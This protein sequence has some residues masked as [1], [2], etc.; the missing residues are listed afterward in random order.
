MMNTEPRIPANELEQFLQ[1]LPAALQQAAELTGKPVRFHGLPIEE[2]AGPAYAIAALFDPYVLTAELPEIQVFLEFPEGELR[3]SRKEAIRFRS[4][5][6]RS[7]FYRLPMLWGG[8]PFRVLDPAGGWRE[9]AIVGEFP[10]CLVRPGEARFAFHPLRVIHRYLN[11][12]Q[13]ETT[14]DFTDLLIHAVLSAGECDMPLDDNEL[15]RDFHAFGI[16]CVLLCQLAICAGTEPDLQRVPALLRRAAAEY[17]SGNIPA[18]RDLLREG[19]EQLAE[20]R[21]RIVARP[22]YFMNIPHGGIQF[23][24]EGFAEYDSPEEAARMLNLYLDWLEKYNY[25]F[26]VDIGVN[27]LREFARANPRTFARLRE[28][29]ASDRVELVNGSFSQP[30][31]HLFPEWD[32]RM[33]FE[34]GQQVLE[35]LFGRRAVTFAAQEISLHPKLPDI[36]VD[37]GYRCA[38]HRCQNLGLAPIDTTPL[39]RWTGPEGKSLRALPSHPLRSDRRGA[40]IYR[41]L[42]VL[43][44]SERNG[45]LP[46]I[47][48][49]NFIDQSFVDI[50][51][52]EVVRANQYAEVW[53]KFVTPLEFFHETA[54]IPAPETRYKLDDYH[55][56]LGHGANSLH[57]H[58][59]GGLSSKHVLLEQEARQLRKQKGRGAELDRFL[60]REA[61]DCYIVPYF[62]TGSFMEG[63]MTDYTGP[64]YQFTNDRPRGIDRFLCDAAGY[65]ERC[66]DRPEALPEPAEWDGTYLRNA[67][68]AVAIDPVFGVVEGRFGRLHANNVRFAAISR[69]FADNRLRLTGTIPSF[70][71]IRLEYF[72]SGGVLYGVAGRLDDRRQ[73]DMAAIEWADAVWF[74]HETAPGEAVIRTVCSVSEPTTLEYF[75]SQNELLIGGRRLLHGGNIFF[76][77]TENAVENRL[78]CYGEFCSSFYWG[79]VL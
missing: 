34:R 69:E 3:N 31:G 73:W 47:A 10:G 7:C 18:V 62:A 67:R 66:A 32:N 53:G 57:G 78:W 41:H 58:Q 51:M 2:W 16:H 6:G 40:E 56:A 63:G 35:E 54:A 71:G 27:T 14:W 26:A 30:Y 21:R 39:I 52:E 44:T 22:V 29:V 11:M 9:I 5:G 24:E 48:F 19:F 20:E 50:Y 76:R 43:L 79:M 70:G 59:T 61:H 42:G 17:R 33:Q 8:V 13:P 25:H 72:L 45:S 37:C 65:P 49:T 36:L 4:R 60:I 38:L 46:F 23:E 75:H 64:R 12:A 68:H 1:T 74:R 77:R 55:Y 28:A 15:R